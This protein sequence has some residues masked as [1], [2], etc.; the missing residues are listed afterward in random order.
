MIRNED[1]GHATRG[2]SATGPSI[3]AE[4]NINATWGDWSALK[5]MVLKAMEERL[6]DAAARAKMT[7]PRFGTLGAGIPRT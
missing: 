5:K 4:A 7:N 1:I 2:A 3:H 6:D